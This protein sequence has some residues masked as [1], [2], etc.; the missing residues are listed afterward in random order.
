M[1]PVEA[2]VREIMI[3]DRL[4]SPRQ[5]FEKYPRLNDWW[6]EE[7]GIDRKENSGTEPSQSR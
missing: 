5:V 1:K 3:K 2:I 7:F 4:K 6:N